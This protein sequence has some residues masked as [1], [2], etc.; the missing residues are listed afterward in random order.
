MPATLEEKTKPEV[1]PKKGHVF[2]PCGVSVK[3]K[4]LNVHAKHCN[5]PVCA[6]ERSQRKR[7]RDFKSEAAREE[8]QKQLELRE[9]R[10]SQA[11]AA[12]AARKL[13]WS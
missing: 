9:Y 2:A 13:Y 10:R 1:R 8:Q 7:E 11:L 4:N 3:R 5:K 12:D 6:A